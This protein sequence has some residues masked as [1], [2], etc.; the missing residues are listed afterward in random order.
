MRRKKKK[1]LRIILIIIV[2]A[3][4]WFLFFDKYSLIKIITSD[5]KIKQKQ[6]LIEVYKKQAKKLK[7]ER[8][9]LENKDEKVIEK[10]ARELGL[11]KPG[12]TIIRIREEEKKAQKGD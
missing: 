1:N 7:I 9:K 12:E 4:I 8:N 5:V 2:I 6:N 11:I 3:L 10:K